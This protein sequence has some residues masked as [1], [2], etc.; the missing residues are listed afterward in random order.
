MLAWNCVVV[1]SPLDA[2]CCF[3]DSPNALRFFQSLV[4]NSNRLPL[5]LENGSL[6]LFVLGRFMAFQ[7][8]CSRY[9]GHPHIFLLKIRFS[10]M[11]P[12][13]ILVRYCII[14]FAHAGRRCLYIHD[15]R[16]FGL[17]KSITT[18]VWFLSIIVYR[19]MISDRSFKISDKSARSQDTRHVFHA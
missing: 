3:C 7:N 14:H 5:D 17:L 13:A 6:L 1:V 4:D 16:E 18:A 15:G 12:S 8:L 2:S 11:V 19:G 10:N 9:T